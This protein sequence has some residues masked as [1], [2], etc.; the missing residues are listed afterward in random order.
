MQQYIYLRKVVLRICGNQSRFSIITRSLKHP[1]LNIRCF[2]FRRFVAK[3]IS[4]L[5]CVYEKDAIEV[6][7]TLT[8][9]DLSFPKIV[10]F[11]KIVFTTIINIFH[12]IECAIRA[13]KSFSPAPHVHKCNKSCFLLGQFAQIKLQNVSQ[14]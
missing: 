8:L 1:V 9:F 13:F 2:L 7:S 14:M 5:L 12:T 6:D 11:I 10:M 4:I 3:E